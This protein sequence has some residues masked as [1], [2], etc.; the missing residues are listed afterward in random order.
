MNMS[1]Y[2]GG[3]PGTARGSVDRFDQ[4]ETAAAFAAIAGGRRVF[5]NGAKKI[6]DDCLVATKI[7]DYRGRGALILVSR[8]GSGALSRG[9]T[10]INGD[11]SIVFEDHR[12]F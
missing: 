9:F 7:I 10:Q 4:G 12:A 8:C 3:P 1:S 5:L 6:L 11:N 2:V